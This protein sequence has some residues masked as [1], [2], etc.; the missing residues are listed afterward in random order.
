MKPF[1]LERALAGD[2]ICTADGRSVKILQNDGTSI[3]LSCEY[4]DSEHA[5]W[6]RADGRFFGGD[7][8]CDLFMAEPA[9]EP[10]PKTAPFDLE[11]ALAGHPLVSRDGNPVTNFS[12]RKSGFSTNEFPFSAMDHD[13]DFL[14]YT[15]SGKCLRARDHGFDLLLDISTPQPEDLAAQVAS[16]VAENRSLKATLGEIRRTLA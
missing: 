14:S 4:G 3:P 6:Y 8:D 12:Q 5:G 11:K 1:N 16:L 10:A 13:G 15:K 9:A 7:R 2:P